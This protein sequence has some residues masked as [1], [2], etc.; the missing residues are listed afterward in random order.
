MDMSSDSIDR[1]GDLSARMPEWTPELTLR[2]AW[3]KASSF[4]RAQRI[5][6]D[7]N[8][9]AE[10]LLL[11]VL[12]CDRSEWFLRWDEPFPREL[13]GEWKRKLERKAAGEPVQYIIGEQ[14]FMGLPFAVEPGVLIPRPE[15][16]ILIETALEWGDRLRSKSGLSADEANGNF[17][18]ADIGTGSGAI[19][20]SLAVLRPSWRFIAVDLSA[21][22][23]EM[24]KRNAERHRAI[25]RI[26]FVEGDLLHPLIDLETIP[27]MILSNPPYISSTDMERLPLEVKQFEP[28]IAL[29]GGEDGFECYRRMLAQIEALPSPPPVLGWECG[30]GQA[31]EV[32]RMLGA[33]GYWKQVHIVRDLA[34]KERHV[35]ATRL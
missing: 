18:V 24:A 35:F 31:Q 15:T 21:H 13:W 10:W 23:L 29:D 33:S 22:A 30:D 8:R 14:E 26:T 19:A 4:L 1:E 20:V 6:Q 11:D 17:L 5:S 27:D 25:D 34:G 2:E 28:K 12:D 32:A 7:A 3:M 16:E 9:V